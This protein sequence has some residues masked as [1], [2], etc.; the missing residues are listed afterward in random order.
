MLIVKYALVNYFVHL[1]D[2][3]ENTNGFEPDRGELTS[4]ILNCRPAESFPLE[5]RV[6]DS[7]DM[8]FAFDLVSLAKVEHPELDD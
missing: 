8:E 3:L 4:R 6:T 2:L 7:S 1:K 5:N